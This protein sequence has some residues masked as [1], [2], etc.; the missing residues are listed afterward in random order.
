VHVLRAHRLGTDNPEDKLFSVF[1]ITGREYSDA[2]QADS[3]AKRRQVSVNSFRLEF[4]FSS[5][6]LPPTVTPA[7]HSEAPE[8]NGRAAGDPKNPATSDH[9]RP[10]VPRCTK[11]RKVRTGLVVGRRVAT[12]MASTQPQQGRSV[13]TSKQ[14][15]RYA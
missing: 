9:V 1:V 15:F 3:P 4:S 5:S 2:P 6:V 13:R 12:S 8:H 14:D 10:W 11:S 7:A